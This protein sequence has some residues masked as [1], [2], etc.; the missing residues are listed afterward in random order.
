MLIHCHVPVVLA[1]FPTLL[2]A[3]QFRLVF[4]AIFILR[5][6]SIIPSAMHGLYAI[7][8]ACWKHFQ[9]FVVDQHF[10]ELLSPHYERS[11][12]LRAL[13]SRWWRE[14]V[15]HFSDQVNRT[16]NNTL[17]D[18]SV[19]IIEDTKIPNAATI[20]IV[21]QDH[22]LGNMLRAHVYL[23]PHCHVYPNVPI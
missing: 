19:E 7:H 6:T 3:P 13:C 9:N 14:A 18:L 10:S 8:F 17:P 21:K 16:L 1:T 4:S 5:V 2:E 15:R 11:Q 12:P 23:R 22:T 20:K